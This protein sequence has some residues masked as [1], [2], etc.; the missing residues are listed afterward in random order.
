MSAVSGPV[1][2]PWDV[3]SVYEEVTEPFLNACSE[4][5][6]GEILHSPPF[7]L[8]QA[9]S[10]IEL[11]DPVMDAWV[12]RPTRKPFNFHSAKEAGHL[13]LENL[14]LPET[15][16]IIDESLLCL[17]SW[18]EGHSLADT[19]LT[20]LY[21]HSPLDITDL[22]MRSVSVGLLR[23]VSILRKTIFRAG[24]FEEEDFQIRTFEMDYL[25]S[26]PEQHLTSLFKEAEDAVQRNTRKGKGELGQ[27]NEMSLGLLARLRFIRLLYLGLQRI[28]VD[29][30]HEGKKRLSLALEQIPT[31]LSSLHFGIV[32][33][34][35]EE[36]LLLGFDPL[37]IQGLLPRTYLGVTKLKPREPSILYLQEMVQRLIFATSVNALNSYHAVL[38]FFM[39]FGKKGTCVL[40]RSVLQSLYQP[41]KA[42]LASGSPSDA[43]S[44]ESSQF[45]DIL[46]EACKS[47]IAPPA[48]M[49]NS[50]SDCVNNFFTN[51]CSVMWRAI[52]ILGHNRARQRDKIAMLLERFSIV[53]EEADKLDTLLHQD[54]NGAQILY[55]STW[56]HYHILRF[57]IRYLLSGFE[58]ELYSSHE[59]TYVYWYLYELLYPWLTSCLF[60]ADTH[61]LSLEQLNESTQQH[62]S[63]KSK[64][65][66]KSN[67][68]K[69][70]QPHTREA[71]S[72]QGYSFLCAGYFKLLIGLK[73]ENKLM[74]PDAE[75]DNVKVRYERRFAPFSILLS[76]PLMPYSQYQEVYDH[77]YEWSS[78]QIF[79]AAAKDFAN[80]RKIF[81][82]ASSSKASEE[83]SK[84]VSVAKNNFVVSS[85]L[86]KDSKRKIDFDFSLHKSFPVVKFV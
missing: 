35:Y 85:I 49:N 44:L 42:T 40:T 32:R 79:N 21:L 61:L 52:V 33:E 29:D 36:G 68:K 81:E 5:D 19:V 55:F 75:F 8:M 12:S 18:L 9:M 58:L 1:S 46:K 50:S 20:N 3:V 80:S 23:L 86:S 11:M 64:K 31:I 37:A 39:D 47:F 10:A 25:S 84:L 16:G 60:R 78:P 4:L 65:K 70:S 30:V 56:L 63:G 7:S 24:V 48:L 26:M 6:L 82:L 67:S 22:S 62:G 54:S 74:S 41:F 73:K 15:I 83:F 34:D 69:K 71:T 2:F 51:C 17:V 77:F 43:S 76:P 27:E 53:Q 59:F 28:Y 45:P 72:Y 66:L 57:M 13:K 38:D 14:S